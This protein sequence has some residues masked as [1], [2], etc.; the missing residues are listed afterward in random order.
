MSLLAGVPCWADVIYVKEGG[1]GGGTSWADAYGDLQDGLDD[2][3]PCD[4]IWVAEGTYYPTSDYGLGIGD[5][6]KHFRM[7]NGVGIYGGFPDIGNPNMADRDPNMYETILSGDLLGNDNPDT[8]VEDLY[9]DPCRLD[10]CYNIFYHIGTNLNKTAILN[11][12]TITGGNANV[13]YPHFFGAGMLNYDYN[14]PTL[15]NCKFYRN[16][17]QED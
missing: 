9:D 3:D 16:S 10:N 13:G 12:F 1:T 15:I 17:A 14:N 4:V 11:G 6:G 8:P 5:R 7:K 2:T